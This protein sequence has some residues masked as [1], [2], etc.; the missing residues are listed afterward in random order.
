MFWEKILFFA[1]KE[2]TALIFNHDVYHSGAK[3]FQQIEK[4]YIIKSEILFRR[5]DPVLNADESY[6]QNETFQEVRTTI[7]F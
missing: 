2:G 3:I 4:K 6:L 5:F 1:P 7:H